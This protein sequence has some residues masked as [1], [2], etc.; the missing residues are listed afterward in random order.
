MDGETEKAEC[1]NENVI[2]GYELQGN[3]EMAEVPC[4]TNL[5]D[6]ADQ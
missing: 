3:E 1:F 6:F 2:E 5:A 4:I